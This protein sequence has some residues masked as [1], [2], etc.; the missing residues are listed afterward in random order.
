MTQKAQTPPPP[1]IRDITRQPPSQVHG[2]SLIKARIKAMAHGAEGFPQSQQRPVKWDAKQAP[3]P[4]SGLLPVCAR[5]LH[6]ASH[7][8]TRPRQ[9]LLAF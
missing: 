7:E 3:R 4:S 9:F 2:I 8:T 1:V 5:Y 6:L